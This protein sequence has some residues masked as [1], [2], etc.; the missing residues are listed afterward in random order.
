MSYQFRVLLDREPA[1]P[2]IEALGGVCDDA[3]LSC[4]LR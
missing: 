1:E 4:V 2:E 3:G